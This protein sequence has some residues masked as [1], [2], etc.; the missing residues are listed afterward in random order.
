MTERYE[1]IGRGTWHMIW[2]TAREVT[3]SGL[4]PEDETDDDEEELANIL[5]DESGGYAGR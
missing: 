2:H 5:R 4:V 3:A 1:V